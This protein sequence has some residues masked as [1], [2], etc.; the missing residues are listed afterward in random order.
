MP[1]GV[2]VSLLVVSTVF[3]SKAMVLS[4]K[5]CK[6]Q[7]QIHWPLSFFFLPHLQCVIFCWGEEGRYRCFRG[8]S[9]VYYNRIWA[10]SLSGIIF[11]VQSPGWLESWLQPLLSPFL[12][13]ARVYSFGSF[14]ASSSGTACSPCSGTQQSLL[15][16]HSTWDEMLSVAITLLTAAL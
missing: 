10:S 5:S 15:L 14:W 12:P 8:L 11:V 13:I 7:G 9:I 3:N 2:L 4:L 6:S 1:G 16:L